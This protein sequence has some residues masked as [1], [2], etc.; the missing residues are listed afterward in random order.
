MWSDDGR[1]FLIDFGAVVAQ[2][3]GS[4]EPGST[5]AGTFGYM[6]PEQTQGRATPQSDLYALGATLL[7]V[8]TNRAIETIPRTRLRLDVKAVTRVSAHFEGCI[9][10]LLEPSPDDRPASA[11]AAR[12]ALATPTPR[13]PWIAS[14]VALGVFAFVL[15]AV[16]SSPRNP[17][18]NATCPNE[19]LVLAGQEVITTLGA[20]G[21]AQRELQH[22]TGRFASTEPQGAG[23][24]TRTKWVL[25]P[26]EEGC[27]RGGSGACARFACLRGI[28]PGEGTYYRYACNT[29]PRSS[30]TCAAAADLDN[31]GR[32]KMY[33]FV[34]SGVGKITAPIPD[35]GDPGD[36]KVGG[37]ARENGIFDCAPD[38]L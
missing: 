23:G 9:Q 27:A 11:T 30:L 25:A 37:P 16:S 34:V 2:S 20:I 32:S 35:I 6:P 36:C 19:V 12:R 21:T 1:A 5:V 24:P 7:N 15:A 29:G 22:R 3:V 17:Q 10:R 8:L 14:L 33:V 13:R 26:C 38:E 4:D 28:A 18:H 31:D